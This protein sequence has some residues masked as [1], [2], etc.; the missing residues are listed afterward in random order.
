MEN[1]ITA[2]F[3]THV[4]AQDAL[5]KLEAIGIEDSQISIVATD[6]TRKGFN[7]ETHSKADKGVAGGATAGGIVGAA[8]GAVMAAGTIVIPGL[9]LVVTGVM[10]GALAGLAAGATTGGLIGGLIGAGIPEHEATIYE[11]ELKS[12]AILIAVKAKD[13]GQKKRVKEA[14]EHTEAYNLAA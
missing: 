14:L 7:L 2:T 3:R 12:G 5:Q 1:L 9:S 11:K 10:A 8:L 6:E 4:A 13:M